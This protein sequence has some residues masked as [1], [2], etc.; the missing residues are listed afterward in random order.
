[1]IETFT[2]EEQAIFIVA[3][4]LLLFAIVMSYAMVQDYR[5]YL[6]GNNKARYSFCD[7]ILYLSVSQT[8]FRHHP[9]NDSISDGNERI[10]ASVDNAAA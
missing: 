4:F 10:G 3:L 8:V 6:D 1:M 9:G 2:K 5:I 7:K